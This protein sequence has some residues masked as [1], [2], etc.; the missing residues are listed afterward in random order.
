MVSSRSRDPVAGRI[1]LDIGDFEARRPRDRS[2]AADGA[3]P[4]QQNLDRKRLGEIIV[5]AGIEAVHDVDGSV[6]RGQHQHRGLIPAFAQPARD[7][8]AV[9][10]GQHHVEHDHVERR[11]ARDFE[12]LPAIVRDHHL[13][14]VFLQSAL[15]QVGHA[16]LVF[17]HQDLHPQDPNRES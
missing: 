4:G 11:A 16:P 9:H 17:D 3:Q 7:R 1:E 6:A 12:P 8:H 14:A 13:M 15:E 5:G 2:A 10:A